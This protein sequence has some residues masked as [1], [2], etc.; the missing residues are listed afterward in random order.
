MTRT[1]I[2]GLA[3]GL[4][5]LLAACGGS[6]SPA[7]STAA[8]A[9]AAAAKPSAAASV[10]APASAPAKP[11]AST[12]ASASAKPAASAAASAKPAASAAAAA[13]AG[14]KPAMKF[15]YSSPSFAYIPMFMAQDAMKAMGY[16][17]DSATF[18]QP[19]LAVQ[20][21]SQNE[22][23]FSSGSTYTVMQAIQKGAKIKL[24]ADRNANE[25]TITSANAIADCAGL[26]GKKVGIASEGAV[27]TAML[28]QW[29]QQ[30]CPQAKPN[31]LVIADSDQR[32]AAML[33][34]QLDASPLQL[35]SQV[36]L[37]KK[38]PGK[39]RTLADFSKEL[40]QLDTSAIYVSS[41]FLAKNRP[42]VV[43]FVG[44]LLKANR[45]VAANPQLLK[46]NN[47]KYKFGGDDVIDDVIKAYLG[48]NAF[49]KNGAVTNDRVAYSI[50]FFTKANQL[51][52]G[53]KVEDVA[54][55]SVLNDALAKVGKQ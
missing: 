20:A 25:W 32:G 17:V 27:S 44:E 9:S 30:K 55:V 31:I 28:N 29:L 15:A 37:Y 18:N 19:E 23:Q 53:L 50:D 33:A 36:A 10:A 45:A 8:P 26:N 5:L 3:V 13:N 39:F 48:I 49:D 41:D 16:A 1:P 42:A 40:P 11:A 12:A 54:D 35:D 38:G 43:D 21:I 14:A 2:P 47:A 24:I 6:A 34:G 52:P 7:S 46:E 51:K 4:L 22:T